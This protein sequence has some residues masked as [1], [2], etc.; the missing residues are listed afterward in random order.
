MATYKVKSGDNLSTIAKK[1][2]TTVSAIVN[3]NKTKYPSITANYIVI[4]WTL[5]IGEGVSSSSEHS[6]KTMDAKGTITSKVGSTSSHDSGKGSDFPKGTSVSVTKY[7]GKCGKYYC[8]TSKLKGWVK[9]GAVQLETSKVDK[10]T[11]TEYKQDYDQVTSNIK[12]IKVSGDSALIGSMLVDNMTGIHGMPYQFLASAD[13]RINVQKGSKTVKSEFGRKYAERIASKMPLVL[14][15][16]GLPDFLPSFSNKDRNT[17]VSALLKA[18][19]G[20]DKLTKNLNS[21]LDK[22]NGRYYTFDF[23]YAEYYGYVNAMLR[24]CAVCLGIKN[25]MHKTNEYSAKFGSFKWQKAI[26]SKLKGFINGNEYV[27]FYIDSETSISESFGNSTTQSAL[28]SS[29]N[30][31]SEISREMQFLAGPIAGIKIDA[32]STESSDD[33]FSN[34]LSDI[35][36][37]ATKYLGN[38]KLF[39]N[40]E[41]GFRTIGKGGKLVFPEIWDDSDFSKSYDIDIKL[42]SPDGDKIS[43]YLNICVPLIHL[44]ALAAPRSMSSNAYKSPFLIRAYYK[45]IFNCDMGIIT[46]MSVT[47]GKESAWTVDG[48]PLEVD[49]SM[50]LKDLYSLFMM[51]NTTGYKFFKNVGLIDYLCNMCGININKPEI[52]RVLETYVLWSKNKISDS[53]SNKWLQFQEALSNYVSDSYGALIFK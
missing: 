40:I 52:N 25:V 35:K 20:S 31:A 7:C 9:E 6:F 50:Q 5:S 30:S 46:S 3:E 36:N 48:L 17:I 23:A 39:S 8:T 49:V 4:G 21:L 32:L 18:T 29:F 19:N 44:I 22:K 27:A 1:Y 24:F 34:A 16:P 28:A 11:A 15:T 38:S 12:N 14:F 43:W 51:T 26:N 53:Y 41:E 47:K 10:A 2:D 42:R 45:G 37:V 13:S 33:A